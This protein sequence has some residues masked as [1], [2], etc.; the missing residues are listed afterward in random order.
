L[1][2]LYDD[3]EREMELGNIEKMEP[4]QFLLNMVSLLVFPSAV[5]PLLMENLIINDEEFDR[6][7]SARKEIILN[8]L[9]KK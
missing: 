4:V 3:I 5:R 6:I 2:K 8:M 9:F 1:K 7:I